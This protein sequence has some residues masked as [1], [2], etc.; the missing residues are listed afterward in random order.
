MNPRVKLG[1]VM[2]G[3]L[4][5]GAASVGLLAP[6]LGQVDDNGPVQNVAGASAGSSLLP[7][8]KGWF[9]THAAGEDRFT[10]RSGR[11]NYDVVFDSRSGNALYVVPET[12]AIAAAPSPT[13]Y[14][15]RVI[16][17]SDT[18]KTFEAFKLERREGLTWKLRSGTDWIKIHDPE[19]I[20]ASMYDIEVI[21][22]GEGYSVLRID[23][24][25][26]KTWILVPSDTGA[27]T[28]RSIVNAR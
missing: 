22:T 24:A 10:E 5:L 12:G 9:R 8:F 18:S 25:S 11:V 16:R 3:G 7:W 15:L 23:E 17:T 1:M 19:P 21:E 14:V 27:S 28:W 4:I 6:L 26:G 2:A 13:N 20:S